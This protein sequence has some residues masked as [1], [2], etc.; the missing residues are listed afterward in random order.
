VTVNLSEATAKD[1]PVRLALSIGPQL[2]DNLNFPSTITVP[3]GQAI[4]STTAGLPFEAPTAT[5]TITASFGGMRRSTAL[6][7]SEVTPPAAA[8]PL[9]IVAVLPNPSTTSEEEVHLKNDSDASVSLSG[10]RI[11]NPQGEAWLLSGNVPPMAVW[12]VPRGG[13]T[14]SLPD[15]G[16]TIR[17]VNPAGE[18]VETKSYGPAAL[19]QLIQV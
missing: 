13:Q 1:L 18:I 2:M 5:Y 12:A 7:V 14:M 15:S 17:L 10:W 9:H 16:G 19:G 8:S 6:I 11:E 3:A 4:A